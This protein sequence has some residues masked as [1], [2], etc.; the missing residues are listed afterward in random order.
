[1]TQYEAL[2]REYLVQWG[3]ES[4]PRDLYLL[5]FAKWLDQRSTEARKWEYTIIGPPPHMLLEPFLAKYGEKGWEMCG[6]FSNI[7]NSLFF[8]K[9]EILKSPPEPS[10]A[11]E[12]K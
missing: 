4:V 10:Q 5:R 11:C 9:R 1:V 8:F 3:G 7:A 6:V 2:A 12:K